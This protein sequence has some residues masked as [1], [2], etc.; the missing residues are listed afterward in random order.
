MKSNGARAGVRVDHPGG[1]ARA[2]SCGTKNECVRVNSIVPPQR[3]HLLHGGHV[4][5]ASVADVQL[6]L[7][8]LRLGQGLDRH[9]ASKVRGPFGGER[10]AMPLEQ[11]LHVPRHLVGL[12][13]REFELRWVGDMWKG[14]LQ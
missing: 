13:A 7:L 3:L 10:D 1:G 14:I 2:V 9:L 12:R 4:P 11:H 6:Q 5:F 8:R